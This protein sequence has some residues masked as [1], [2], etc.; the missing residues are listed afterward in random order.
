MSELK[1]K[2]IVNFFAFVAVVLIAV[3]MLASLILAQIGVSA[4]V[5]GSIRLIGEIIAYI[6]TMIAAFHF[7]RSKRSLPITLTYAI[8]ATAIL[9]LLILR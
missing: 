1:W 9:V 4:S 2:K 6:I 8:S 7:V 5:L 3:A